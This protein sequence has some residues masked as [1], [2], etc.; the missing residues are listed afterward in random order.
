MT[1]TMAAAVSAAGVRDG[2]TGQLRLEPRALLADQPR[3]SGPCRATGKPSG[4]VSAA[5][6]STCP[7]S[8]TCWD[9]CPDRPR[10]GSRRPVGTVRGRSCRGASPRR[11]S[12]RMWGCWP[13]RAEAATSWNSLRLPNDSTGD[14][15]GRIVRRL[16]EG[17]PTGAMR[18]RGGSEWIGPWRHGYR[19]REG[20]A[21][22]TAGRSFTCSSGSVTLPA[23]SR[24]TVVAG[25]NLSAVNH[26]PAPYLHAKV[27]T[28]RLSVGLG[29]SRSWRNR[30][31]GWAYVVR[32]A[33]MGDAHA[34]AA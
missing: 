11:S 12:A 32:A 30:L 28:P 4:C 14:L 33:L 31:A 18:V 26:F 34:S 24:S 15:G 2:S 6:R 9:G 22:C 29:C 17:W 27:G 1:V 19:G 13:S 21:Q 3:S 23:E 25:S 7:R 20:A 5:P 16:L 8:P 10:H